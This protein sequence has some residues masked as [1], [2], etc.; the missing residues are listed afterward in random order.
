MLITPRDS[1]QLGL[2][3]GVR[4]LDM[5]LIAYGRAFEHPSKIRMVRWLAGRL[6]SGRIR[7]RYTPRAVIGIDPADYVGWAVFKTGYY[8][9]ASLDLALRIMAGN[10]GLFVDVG[11]NFGWYTCAVGALAG[12]TVISIEPN[13][14][15]CSLLR[16]NIALNRLQNAIIFNGAVG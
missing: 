2:S 16:A 10:P 4:L 5:A 9:R 13:C 8:E 12:S 7:V 6:A 15:N 1:G 11:A 14:Q 3:Q